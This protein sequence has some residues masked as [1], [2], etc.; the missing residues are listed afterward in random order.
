MRSS[1]LS[2]KQV[3]YL[4]DLWNRPGDDR[5][6][7]PAVR[8]HSQGVFSVL[9]NTVSRSATVCKTRRYGAVGR[10]HFPAA[11]EAARIITPQGTEGDERHG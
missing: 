8:D 7:I 3:W 5:A 9:R 2:V 1:R 11:T 4:S 10:L 6:L